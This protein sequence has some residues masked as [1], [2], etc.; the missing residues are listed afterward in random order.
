MSLDSLT[1]VSEEVFSSLTFLP[2]QIIGR[3]I[4][5]HTKKLG[6]PEI[7]GTKIAIIGVEE[8]R[9]SFFPT[10]KYSLENFRKEFYR[11]YPGNWDFQISDLG[12]LPN[13]AEPEDTYFAL[14][15]ISSH[16][17]QLN[18]ISVIIGGSHDII[19]PLYESYKINN[20]LVNIVSVDNQFDFSQEEELVSG[21]SYMSKI[22]TKQ[23]NYLNNYTNLGYQSYLIAQEELD[24][25]EKLH[26]ESIRLG[27]LL[28]KISIAEPHLR[29]ADITGFDMK[30]LSWDAAQNNSGNPNGIDS[31]TICS[32]ARY[33]GLSDRLTCFGIF[34]LF[35]STLFDKLIAQILWYFIE[36]YNCRFDEYPV[37]TSQGY[38]KYT[39]TLS[40]RE[41]VF[42]QSEKSKR[43]WI[44]ITNEDYLNNKMKRSTLLSC[45][46]QDYLD[47]CNDKLPD[48][49]W[50]EIK[51]G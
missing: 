49:W 30:V 28:D 45:T 15:E 46:H 11:L 38:G 26:F 40:D 22:I 5:I 10:Q 25:I 31:R 4:K 35:P 12:D 33:A 20:Q 8:I 44:E 51:R 16:L 27:L 36:G 19:Y 47:A 43:W 1:P 18:I 14:K 41:L 17:R 39:V 6:F 48:R 2:R 24:L 21:R 50:K 23:P 29:D 32:L 42:Y 9:N 7:Q 37:L 3:N 13:G 34:E